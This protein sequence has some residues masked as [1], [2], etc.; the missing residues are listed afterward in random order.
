MAAIRF[1]WPISFQAST[2]HELANARPLVRTW[3]AVAGNRS[4]H[5][6]RTAMKSSQSD[7]VSPP[8]NVSARV[9]G[10]M[11]VRLSFDFTEDPPVIDIFRWLR[12]HQAIIV[13]PFRDQKRV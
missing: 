8:V 7:R 3:M 1:G 9:E 12:T 2:I 13:A 11:S 4:R 6:F 5:S 10:S